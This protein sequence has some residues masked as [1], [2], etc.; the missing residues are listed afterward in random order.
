MSDDTLNLTLRVWR[1]NGPED[2]GGFQDYQ[3][4]G[5]STHICLLYTSDAADE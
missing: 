3:L 2:K 1:Q 5:V 4:N